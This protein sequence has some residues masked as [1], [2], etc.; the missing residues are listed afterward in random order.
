M[1]TARLL[2]GKPL[3][4]VLAASVILGLPAT[5]WI[6]SPAVGEAGVLSPE[7]DTI[8]I[9]MMNSIFL[10]VVFLPIVCVITWLCLRGKDNAGSLLAWDRTK[11]IRSALVTLCFAIPI[12]FGLSSLIG[13][14]TA[15]PGWHGLWWLP[16]TLVTLFWLSV[17]RGSAV[18]KSKGS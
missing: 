14:F 17:M 1:V 6:Y 3:A 8:I 10:A 15:P 2:L 5:S 12:C 7:A 13:E 16:Y 11:P 18:S 4:W 9:P